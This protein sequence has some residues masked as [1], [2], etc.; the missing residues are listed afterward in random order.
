MIKSTCGSYGL[1][2]IEDSD[3]KQIQN[4]RNSEELRKFFRE[5]RELSMTQIQS[6]YNQMIQSSKFEMFMIVDA[7]NQPLGVAGMTYIDFI[8]KHADIH[9]Y[10][11]KDEEWIDIH[12]TNAIFPIILQYGFNTL[13]LNKIWAEVYDIDRKKIDLFTKYKFSLD[14]RLR[15]HYYYEGRYHDSL[16]FSLL[17]SDYSD[18][19]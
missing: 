2:C 6:W 13:N 14:G 10:I 7:C 15:K 1:R 9:F 5:Y 8:N 17:K 19:F 11:G 3:L 12:C 18:Q 16:I 4:W